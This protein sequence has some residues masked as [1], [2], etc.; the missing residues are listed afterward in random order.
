M[1]HQAPLGSPAKS[2][3]IEGRGR[4]ASQQ[5]KP[6]FCCKITINQWCW[7]AT[8]SSNYSHHTRWTSHL[9]DEKHPICP[10]QESNKWDTWPHRWCLSICNRPPKPPVIS[11]IIR[12]IPLWIIFE[13]KIHNKKYLGISN[14]FLYL[15]GSKLT[16]STLILLTKNT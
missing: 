13:S 5:V 6:P 9:H 10:V 1:A 14:I 11:P 15:F 12:P 4:G 3:A 8:T 7:A 16:H 2:S